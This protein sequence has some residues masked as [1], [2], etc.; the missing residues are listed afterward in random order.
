L[1]GKFDHAKDEYATVHVTNLLGSIV[2]ETMIPISQDGSFS[3]RI[4]FPVASDGVYMLTLRN[5][6][7]LITKKIVKE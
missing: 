3:A 4:D 5:A 7:Q 6:Q 2:F 1:N